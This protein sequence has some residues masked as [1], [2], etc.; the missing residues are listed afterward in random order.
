[1][2]KIIS[3][4]TILL[5]TSIGFGQLTITSPDHTP[6]NPVNCANYNDASVANF[7]DNGGATGDYTPGQSETFTICPDLSVTGPK[8]RGSFANSPGFTWDVHA[9]DTLYVYDGPTTSAPLLGKYNNGNA[10]G[11]FS[12]TASWANPSGCLT[13]VFI[14][15]GTMQGTGWDANLQCISPPQDIVIHVEAFINGTPGNDMFPLDT[16]YVDICQGD[17]VLLVAKPLFP[18]SSENTGSGYSQNIN[19]VHYLWEFSDGS[20]APNNDSVWFV[21]N[22]QGGYYINLTITDSYPSNATNKFRVRT[23]T[24]PSFLGTGP[25]NDTVCHNHSTEL[26]GG[27]T[28]S[29]TVGV[30]VP[31]G[32]FQL[33]GNFAGLT[34]LPDGSNAHYTT[35]INMSGFPPGST[36]QNI[37]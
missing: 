16:G 14:S 1:M 28:V 34:Y 4:F 20:V 17:S 18:Y 9:S 24:T 6:S 35:S 23:S 2:K 33:G 5:S 30:N 13:F 27:V 25:M 32:S 26:F 19:N 3:L 11:G 37:G 36:I 29:D 15:D 31:E 10:P 21:P 7:Y 22:N 12:H 8:I